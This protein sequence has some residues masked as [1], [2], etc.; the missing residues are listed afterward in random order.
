MRIL[1][2]MDAEQAK[3]MNEPA[4]TT[5]ITYCSTAAVATATSAASTCV[6]NQIQ[7]SCVQGSEPSA[8]PNSG[9]LGA[10][11]N[12]VDAP[13]ND[14]VRINA[15]QASQAA[16]DYCANLISAGVVLDST[17]EP[18]RPGIQ[19]GA[20]ENGGE[21]ALTVMFDVDSC[22]PNTAAKDQKID[23]N[24]LGQQGCEM[25]LFTLIN[26]ACKLLRFHR[27]GR[28]RS[29]ADGSSSF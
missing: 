19:P 18:S 8:T 29:K 15:D 5:T 2:A 28:E 11:C 12:K 26:A 6:G 9:P 23:F 13:N 7:G 17:A 27:L 3:M 24:S 22:E 20:A 25:A 16:A 4:V 1:N 10:V 21:L 14:L